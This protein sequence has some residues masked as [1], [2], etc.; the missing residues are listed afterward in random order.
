MT[1]DGWTATGAVGAV[2]VHAIE[3]VRSA[4]PTIRLV[5]TDLDNTLYDWVG[6]YAAALQTMVARAAEIV[7]CSRDRLLDELRD[8]YTAR[9][10]V[11]EPRAL[12]ELPVVRQH[13]GDL[14]VA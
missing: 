2:I 1:D 6:W 5:I 3:T 4:A 8:A 13:F 9:G 12:L 7:G 14:H 11:E 10:S